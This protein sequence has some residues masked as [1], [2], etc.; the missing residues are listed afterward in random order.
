MEKWTVFWEVPTDHLH[1]SPILTVLSTWTNSL[2]FSSRS[3][4]KFSA[5]NA[6]TEEAVE[7]SDPNGASITTVVVDATITTVVVDE[8]T[9]VVV[10]TF[11]KLL[12]DS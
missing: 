4:P 12:L 2:E 3:E 10:G 8:T 9:T 11:L 7:M 6:T 1:M 5:N